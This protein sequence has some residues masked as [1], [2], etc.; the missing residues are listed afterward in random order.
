[1]GAGDTWTEAEKVHLKKLW[2]DKVR[3]PQI[4]VLM[5][6]SRNAIIG[7]SH[8]FMLPVRN[9]DG[10]TSPRGEHVKRVKPEPYMTV[11]ARPKKKI[12]NWSAT[13]PREKKAP[14]PVAPPESVTGAVSLEDLRNHHCRAIV[15]GK[16]PRWG[17]AMYCGQP[18]VNETYC[19]I[20]TATYWNI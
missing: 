6:K 3:T 4:A 2:A 16:D 8:R 10:S 12:P 13:G 5:G 18:K 9:S 11:P 19:A 20:H 15:G 7:A 17:L 14:T 1:M